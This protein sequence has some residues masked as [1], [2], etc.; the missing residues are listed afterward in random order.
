MDAD[1]ASGGLQQNENSSGTIYILVSERGLFF[2]NRICMMVQVK[3]AM[4][5]LGIKQDDMNV[6]LFGVDIVY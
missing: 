4:D 6:I 5:P 3:L 2:A 1:F